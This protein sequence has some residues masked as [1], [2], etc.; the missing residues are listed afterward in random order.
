MG[1]LT[2]RINDRRQPT[3]D[4]VPLHERR[5]P[6]IVRLAREHRMPVK[7]EQRE[8]PRVAA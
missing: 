3:N 1:P 6:L 7:V 5:E 4:I 2:Q 8:Y